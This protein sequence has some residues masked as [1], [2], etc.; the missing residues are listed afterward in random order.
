MRLETMEFLPFDRLVGVVGLLLTIFAVGF[1]LAMDTRSRAE[2]GASIACFVVATVGFLCTIGVWSVTAGLGSIKR[3]AITGLLCAAVGVLFLE[4]IRWAIGRHEAKHAAKGTTEEGRKGPAK[5]SLVFVFGAPLGDNESALW[6]MVLEHYGPGIAHNCKI[7]FYDD[8]RKNIEHEWL[9]RHPDSPY[10]PP[11]LAGESQRHL[12]VAEASPE[13]AV[14]T[15]KWNPLNPNSQHYTVIIDCR[16]GVF[17]EKW[18]IARVDGI[19]RSRITIAHGPQWAKN[20]PDLEPIVFRYE[21]PE[22]VKTA[23]ATELPKSNT[24]KVVHPGW[25]SARFSVPAVIID[26][27]GNLQGLSGVKLPDGSV[28][29]DFGSWNILTRHFGD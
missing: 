19:L 23:L 6:V 12:Y 28:Q 4:S 13:G 21:D 15:F 9:V 2:L 17:E 14:G 22:F 27:T 3:I 18:E 29:T 10:P 20:N 11:G 5:P 26:P 7:A 24:G 8:D 1:G 16:D 25:K